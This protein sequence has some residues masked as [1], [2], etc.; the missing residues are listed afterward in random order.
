M[1]PMRGAIRLSS[2]KPTS[3]IFS[4]VSG[5]I[6]F[7]RKLATYPICCSQ[8]TPALTVRLGRICHESWIYAASERS[9]VLALSWLITLHLAERE[10]VLGEQRVRILGVCVVAAVDVRLA[11]VLDVGEV[12]QRARVPVLDRG[13]VA[14]GAGRRRVV[15]AAMEAGHRVELGPAIVELR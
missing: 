8:R 2:W 5:A 3:G 13:G 4:P 15:V 7:W 11:R 9:L 6:V 10:V 12:V 1:K 14:P